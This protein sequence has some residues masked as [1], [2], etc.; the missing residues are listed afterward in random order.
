MQLKP[1]TFERIVKTVKAMQFD[2]LSEDRAH[3]E[4]IT[5]FVGNAGIYSDRGLFRKVL[6]ERTG[7]YRLFFELQTLVGIKPVHHSNWIARD[8]NM[9]F[10]IYTD[11]AFQHNYEGI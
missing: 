5:Q 3:L 6:H 2:G 11:R 1:M 9:N 4:A 8:I 7:K 10:Y